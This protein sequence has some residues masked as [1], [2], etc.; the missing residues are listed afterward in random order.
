VSAF[1]LPYAPAWILTTD[2]PGAS[3]G[4]PVLIREEAPAVAYGPGDALRATPAG[5]DPE[6]AAHFVAAHY[7]V[8][9]GLPA[10]VRNFLATA[11][12]AGVADVHTL[13]L[14]AGRHLV[15]ADFAA[16]ELGR[17]GGSAHTPAKVAASRAN[18]RRGGRPKRQP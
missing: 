12:G 4:R 17:R 13:S 8:G 11:A 16:A 6:L 15:A 14:L 3:F 5:A 10:P 9:R 1:R 2:H 7:Q 18:G